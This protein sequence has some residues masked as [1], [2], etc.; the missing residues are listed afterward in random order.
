M[1]N[2][3]K[4]QTITMKNS[5]FPIFEP[6]EFRKTVSNNW[7][8]FCIWAFALLFFSTTEK[9]FEPSELYKTFKFC[10]VICAALLSVYWAI[11]GLWTY[12]SLEGNI[13][14]QIQFETDS[15][16]INQET[17]QLTNINKLDIHVEDYF[18]RQT[19]GVGTNFTPGLSQ[20]VNNFIEFTDASLTTRRIYFNQC[21]KGEYRELYPFF[22]S[23]IKS[24]K[25]SFLRGIEILEITEYEAIKEFKKTVTGSG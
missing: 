18:G 12:E 22:V 8:I 25:I 24:R 9:Y 1:V 6:D 15:F 7:I 2:L 21:V 4:K 20:G 3:N 17:I 14:G 11:A 13:T 23:A 5:S 10:Y 16:E 19:R